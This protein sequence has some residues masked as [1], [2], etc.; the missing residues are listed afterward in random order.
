M[1]DIYCL[2]KN[3]S[4]F[5]VLGEIIG[6]MREL[7]QTKDVTGVTFKRYQREYTRMLKLIAKRKK[8]AR[9]VFISLEVVMDMLEE[10]APNG[11]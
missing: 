11:T 9:D 6:S 4:D 10:I 8:E 5:G 7:K 2:L 1:E 3:V